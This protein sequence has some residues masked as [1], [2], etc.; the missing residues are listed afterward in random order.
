[1][2]RKKKKLHE[3]TL[4][5]SLIEHSKEII[6]IKATIRSFKESLFIAS[7]THYRPISMDA[8]KTTIKEYELKIV[9][10][11][12]HCANLLRAGYADKYIIVG[13]RFLLSP[14]DMSAGFVIMTK[15]EKKG[16]KT[17]GKTPC[18]LFLG[19][20]EDAFLET[21]PAGEIHKLSAVEDRLGATQSVW[22][23]G[24]IKELYLQKYKDQRLN[25]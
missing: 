21:I 20:N 25:I 1:M 4:I 15:L 24:S 22:K 12:Q 17:I 6:A 11:S 19:K 9:D 8:I 13:K 7:R 10:I 3:L 2:S 23:H 14:I 5:E 16:S 18:V